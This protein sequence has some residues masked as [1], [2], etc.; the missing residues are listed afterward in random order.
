[1]VETREFHLPSAW[2]GFKT[3]VRQDHSCH[4]VL[5]SKRVGSCLNV[6]NYYYSRNHVIIT[7]VIVITYFIFIVVVVII[8]IIIISRHFLVL[9]MLCRNWFPTDASRCMLNLRS[10]SLAVLTVQSPI[11]T[12]DRD[13]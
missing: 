13:L 9:V 3:S 6:L 5:S 2:P 11:Y 1:M 4:R 12:F 7:I 10:F 8:V